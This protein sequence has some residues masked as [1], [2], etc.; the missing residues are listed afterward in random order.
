MSERDLSNIL[1][2][3]LWLFGIGIIFLPLSVTLFRSF[4]DKGYIFAKTLGVVVLS[5]AMFFLGILKILPFNRL[6]L[7][8]LFA[9][10][11]LGYILFLIRSKDISKYVKNYFS[12][13]RPFFF[14]FLAE[15]IL[16]L[17]GIYFLSYVRSFSPDIHGLE[18][19]MDF[20]FIN[21]I[22]RSTYFPPADMWFPPLSINYYYFGHLATAVLIK[23]TSITPGISYNLMLATIFSLCLV[24]S[25]SLGGN[26][27]ASFLKSKTFL[28][29]RILIVA[30]LSS[31]LVTLGGN[32]HTLYTFFKPYENEKPV[33]LWELA[34]SPNSFPNAYWY[35]NATRYI[36]NTIHEFPIYSW[37]VADLHGHVLD[38]P[39]VLL[40][41]A[42]LFSLFQLSFAQKP[43]KKHSQESF[44]ASLQSSGEPILHILIG[45]LLAVMYM[46]NAWDGII[47]FLLSFFVVLFANRT[48]LEGTEKRFSPTGLGALLKSNIPYF[49]QVAYAML[50]ISISFFLFAQPFTRFFK[51]FVSGIGVLCAPEFLTNIGKLGPFLFEADHCQHSPWWQLLI[52]YGLFYFF[53]FS[54]FIL[55][56]KKNIAKRA[57]YF[58]LILVFLSTLLILIPEFI[59]AKDIYP[60]HYRANTMF[61]L[62]FQAFM[63]LGLSSGYIF[64][65]VISY[66]KKHFYDY[67]GVRK[68]FVLLYGG[69]SAVLITLVLIYPYLAFNSYYGVWQPI[70]EGTEKKQQTLD[71]LFYLK[72]LY[73]EDYE[74]ISWMNKNIPGQPVVLEAQGDS[75]TDHARIS[76]NTGLP[77]VLG[78]TVHEWL[79]R[80]SY[81]IPS[82][83]IGEVTLM[84][85]TDDTKVASDLLKKH[86]VKY[87]VIGD[88][89]RQK[90]PKLSEAKFKI[91]GRQVYQNGNT[92]L[93]ELP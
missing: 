69:T 56:V 33:P 10:P 62:V 29:K 25:F 82:P 1:L 36:H 85:E 24:S 89:E 57:D 38:I 43:A 20:G 4:T 28:T 13:L 86:H 79:W 5:Y 27:F 65:R 41:I 91:L 54:F 21:S 23:L 78:W 3:W 93:H 87:V 68:V 31:L 15:E 67:S 75:Y 73:P 34:F 19:F 52:L 50:T 7:F 48:L 76:A 2:W 39:F 35:P 64:V 46:T 22:G 61:K 12:N 88:L 51:P 59:Y 26:F 16:F 44:V 71:G 37:T 81:D 9:L 40:V 77:T 74:L 66:L 55:L 8:F 11:L 60:A 70:P 32:I 53:V 17:A 83:R 30:V 92:R 63:M 90:Y 49:K 14:I 42:V 6:S 58:V 72:N 80:G 47:Y 18:K 84:Y 45:F